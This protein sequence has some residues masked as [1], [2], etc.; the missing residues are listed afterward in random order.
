LKNSTNFVNNDHFAT[1]ARKRL[2][3]KKTMN[4][5]CRRPITCY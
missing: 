4:Q 1:T 2:Q 3:S 5:Y